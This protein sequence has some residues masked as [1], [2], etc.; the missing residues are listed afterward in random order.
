MARIGERLLIAIDNIGPGLTAIIS[1]FYHFGTPLA[2]AL[3]QGAHGSR[4]IIAL[5]VALGDRGDGW[6]ATAEPIEGGNVCSVSRSPAAITVPRPSSSRGMRTR[7]WMRPCRS[8]RRHGHGPSLHRRSHRGCLR[9]A[10]LAGD[11]VRRAWKALAGLRA[12]PYPS[13][14]GPVGHASRGMALNISA[15]WAIIFA[16]VLVGNNPDGHRSCAASS[17]WWA[18]SWRPRP[19]SLKR[20]GEG[21]QLPGMIAG[22]APNA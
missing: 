16:L 2:V 8:A 21:Q 15:R 13:T 18:R 11:P 7:L 14:T 10:A 1:M 9:H 19:T 12:R 3:L 17:S 20:N 22:I 5:L 4:Q 6:S